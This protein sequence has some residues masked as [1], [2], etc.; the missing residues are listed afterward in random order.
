MMFAGHHTTSGTAA[1]TLIEL[2][3]HP[4]ELAAVVAELDALDGRRRRRS[5]T[6]R[7]ARCRRL[8]AAIK[9]ALRLH[10]PL[11]LL[12]R[13]A[14]HDLEVEGY[15]DRRRASWSAPRRRSPTAFPRPSPIPT[16]SCPSRY[17]DPARRGPRQPVELDPVR[18]RPSPLRGRGVRH[19]AAQ[20]HLLA[21]C[22]SDWT[23]ELAQP[24][25]TLPQ[26]PLE[27][28]RAARA[29]VR[30]AVPAAGARPVTYRIIVDHDLCQGHGVCECE[31]PEVF[32]VSKKASSPCSTRRRPTTSAPPSRRAGRDSTAPP[33]RYRIDGTRSRRTDGRAIPRE[34]TGGDG[35]A[36][37]RG[38]PRAPRQAGDWKPMA[39]MYTEDATY[40]WNFGPTEEFMAVGREEIREIAL[41]LEMAGPRR[42][43]LPVHGDPDRRPQGPRARAVETGCRRDPRRRHAVRD[44][45]HRREL[46]SLRR[47][48]GSGAGSATSSTSATRPRCS[49]R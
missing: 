21:C 15:H 13:V 48:T 28:G 40:G 6:R 44:R 30:R 31:A 45:R 32:S 19:D 35:R 17:L 36:V 42:L 26:R 49:S 8:E 1:W 3:R 10:P 34:E 5:A 22:C 47:A 33:M 20:G 7:C 27:D 9:E 43:E 14:K 29:A 11:I 38:Q 4:G 41:G 12:L 24:P 25:D 37:A 16:R 39:D 2:L 46:V 23:F 18:C